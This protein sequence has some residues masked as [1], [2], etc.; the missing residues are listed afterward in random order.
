MTDKTYILGQ[1][2]LLI[3]I[4]IV[5]LAF[6]ILLVRTYLQQSQARGLTRGFCIALKLVGFGILAYCL[7]EP[8]IRGTRPTPGENIFVVLADRSQSLNIKNVDSKFGQL[9]Q[10]Y[11]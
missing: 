9:L 11:L 7:L 10:F 3:P 4:L 8:L 2:Q 5:G 6:A 1:P